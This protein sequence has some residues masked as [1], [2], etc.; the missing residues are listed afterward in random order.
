[1]SSST[2]IDYGSPLNEKFW[3]ASL[4]YRRLKQTREVVKEQD[5]EHERKRVEYAQSI[6][7]NERARQRLLK[8]IQ[9]SQRRAQLKVIPGG[10]K[11]SK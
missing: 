4:A 10:K 8:D 6:E 5:A 2:P 9:A 11:K 3:S 7:E 1:M